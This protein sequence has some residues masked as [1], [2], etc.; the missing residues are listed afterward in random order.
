MWKYEGRGASKLAPKCETDFN[1]FCLFF[2]ILAKIECSTCKT[3]GKN[4]LSTQFKLDI[5]FKWKRRLSSYKA[6]NLLKCRWVQAEDALFVSD[7]VVCC[8]CHWESRPHEGG[9]IDQAWATWLEG[10]SAPNGTQWL[11]WYKSGVLEARSTRDGD[12]GGN[13]DNSSF[14]RFFLTF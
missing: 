10:A 14:A 2:A 13:E 4:G 5:F 1:P 11:Q 8:R 7:V 9:G 12:T 3:V 6:W